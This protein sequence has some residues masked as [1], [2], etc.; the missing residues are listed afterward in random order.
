MDEPRRDPRRIIAAALAEIIAGAL[1]IVVGLAEFAVSSRSGLWGAS[2]GLIVWGGLMLSSG[3]GLYFQNGIARVTSV[4][5]SVL[6]ALGAVLVMAVSES[7]LLSMTASVVLISGGIVLYGVASTASWPTLLGLPAESPMPQ[8]EEPPFTISVAGPTP[9]GTFLR[10]YVLAWT[11]LGLVAFGIAGLGALFEFG[12]PMALSQ[13]GWPAV[14]GLTGWQM[15]RAAPSYGRGQRRRLNLFLA[16][17]GVPALLLGAAVVLGS[18]FT[19][20]IKTVLNVS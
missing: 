1:T 8:V 5:F 15:F 10:F 2:G 3:I 19:G 14:W 17:P 9:I 20:L 11:V 16:I 7:L 13:S 18:F 12:L 6:A 4:V